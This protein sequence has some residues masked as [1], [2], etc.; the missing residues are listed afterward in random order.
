MPRGGVRPFTADQ[1]EDQ[2]ALRISDTGRGIEPELLTTLF[3]PYER[4]RTDN[5]RRSSIQAKRRVIA[6]AIKR[7]NIGNT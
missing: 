3:E 7:A 2:V 5:G 4:R 6:R 1:I